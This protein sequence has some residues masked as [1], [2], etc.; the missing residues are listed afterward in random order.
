VRKSSDS[1]R[2]VL[3]Q[4]I[5]GFRKIKKI[6]QEE[7]A[8]RCGLHRTYIGS[9]EREERN[10][11]LSTLEVLANALEVKVTRLLGDTENQTTSNKDLSVSTANS[12]NTEIEEFILAFKRLTSSQRKRIS[13]TIAGFEGPKD[14][15]RASDSDLISSVLLEY[16][17]DQLLNHHANSRQ[18]L[19]KDRF[20][21]AFESALNESGIASQL[22]QSRTNRGHDITIGGIPVSLKTE[23]A[24][25]IRQE[26]IHISKWMELGKGTWDLPVLRDSFLEHMQHYERIFTLRCLSNTPEKIWYELVEIPKALL[27]EAQ[28]CEFE[29]KTDSK[30]TPQPGYGYVKDS[31][32]QLQFSLYFDGGSERKLQIKGLRKNLC[33]VH[34]VWV[35]STILE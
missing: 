1:L 27:L 17:G 24:A 33:K 15:Q 22:V 5:K 29:V 34:A 9:V 20:E 23:A 31:T 25:N 13:T 2:N 26:I 30:Q 16:F 32:G 12:E 3:A 10:V 18:V 7:L 8:E 21:F 35:F 4:N 6:S 19:S 14:F 28:T 11:T